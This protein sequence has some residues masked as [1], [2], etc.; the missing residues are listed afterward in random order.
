[1]VGTTPIHPD[2]SFA[3]YATVPSMF[4]APKPQN[5]SH[6][7]AATIPFAALAAW[8]SL[9]TFAGAKSGQTVLVHGGGGPVGRLCLI[10]FDCTF[11]A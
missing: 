11:P 1:M 7:L 2:G 3:Q 6:T 5:I 9:F 4:I 8:S 10:T